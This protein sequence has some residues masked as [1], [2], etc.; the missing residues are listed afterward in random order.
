[1]VY[2]IEIITRDRRRVTLETSIH[3][4]MRDGRPIE[5]QG[6]ALPSAGTLTQSRAFW[7]DANFPL[8]TLSGTG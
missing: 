8:G 7:L 3:L 1:V 2:E 4:V 5:I 6:I